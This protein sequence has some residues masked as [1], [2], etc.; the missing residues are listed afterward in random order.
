MRTCTCVQACL[1]Q[2]AAT[3]WYHGENT[4]RF[5]CR[6]CYLSPGKHFR[7]SWDPAQGFTEDNA[8]GKHIHLHKGWESRRWDRAH[9][10]VK[11]EKGE[12]Q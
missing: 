11:H 8:K 6:N 5:G 3:I 9:T 10:E 1:V 2:R 4:I 12:Y 7:V